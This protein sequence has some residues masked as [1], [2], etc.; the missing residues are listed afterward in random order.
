MSNDAYHQEAGV[1]KTKTDDIAPECGNS[2]RHY[3]AKHLA[4]NRTPFVPSP[5]MVKGTAIHTAVLEPDNLATEFA[6]A[7]E[8]APR[9]PDARQRNAKKPSAET[10]DSIAFWDAFEAEAAG[11]TVLDAET[12][13]HVVGARDSVLTH[14]DIKGLFTLGD[15]EESYFA[16]DPETGALIKCRPDYNRL[17]YDGL[18]IDLKSTGDASPEGFSG[19]ATKFRYD[20]S[21]PWYRD[22]IDLALGTKGAAQNFA[23]VAVEADPP[24]AVGLYYLTE[25]QRDHGR[26]MGRRDLRQIVNC[27][28]TG[29]WPDWAGIHGAR[30]LDIR[31]YARRYAA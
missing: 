19:S 10:L 17:N 29:V 16:I 11:K 13:S 23:F 14:P 20:V 18:V 25:R 22:V 28:S 1:S 8:D 30:P 9:R 12:F 3:W 6:V 24:H 26:A 4:P 5:Q 21:D 2:P 31:P 27:T 7:P 15:A